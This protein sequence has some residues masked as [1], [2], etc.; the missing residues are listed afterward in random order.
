M[1]STTVNQCDLASS[2]LNFLTYYFRRREAF[3]SGDGLEKG[4][5]LSSLRRS[6]DPVMEEVEPYSVVVANFWSMRSERL[7]ITD[8]VNNSHCPCEGQSLKGIHA[9]QKRKPMSTIA[10]RILLHQ[11]IRKHIHK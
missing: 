7:A 11:R 5:S 9:A 10:F 3:S 4:I 2:S 6:I 1:G 8:T